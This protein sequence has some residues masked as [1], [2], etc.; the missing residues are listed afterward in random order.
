[1]FD[2]KLPFREWHTN[3]KRT[4]KMAGHEIKDNVA[5]GTV[6]TLALI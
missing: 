4:L 5:A 3:F 2:G 1:M 6:A